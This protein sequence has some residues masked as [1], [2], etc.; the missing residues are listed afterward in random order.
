MPREVRSSLTMTDPVAST[1]MALGIFAGLVTLALAGMAF[2]SSK[3][4]RL[5]GGSLASLAVTLVLM[6]VSRDQLR[7]LML[8][9]AG[10]ETSPWVE[11]QRG[12]LAIFVVLLVAAAG[13]VGWMIRVRRSR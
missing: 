2:L 12:P 11:T 3:P 10:H 9:R 6:V 8:A 4:K 5:L 7:S 1:V 13:I